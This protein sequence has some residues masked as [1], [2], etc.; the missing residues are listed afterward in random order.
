MVQATTD[1][2]RNLY[3][4]QN[5]EYTDLASAEKKAKELL[6]SGSSS[7]GIEK[8]GELLEFMYKNSKDEVLLYK[9]K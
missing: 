3:K 5:V 7:I 1:K 6:T 8:N 2:Y 9:Y 4:V